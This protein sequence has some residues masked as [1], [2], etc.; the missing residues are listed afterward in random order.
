M[1]F[2]LL[3]EHPDGMAMVRAL[4]ASGRHELAVYSGSAL[5][6]ESLER[7]DLHPARVG[8]LEEVLA[9]PQIEAVVVAGGPAVRSAQ[10]RRALQAERHVLC[11]HP[12]DSSPDTAYEMAMLQNDVGVVLLPLL[13]EALHPGVRRLV[14]CVHGLDRVSGRPDAAPALRE[15]IEPDAAITRRERS[16]PLPAVNVFRLVEVRRSGEEV[17]RDAGLDGQEPG[18]PGWEVLRYLG[19]ELAEVTALSRREDLDRSDVVLLA[20]QFSRGALFQA[21]FLPEHP[22]EEWRLVVLHDLGRVELLFEEGWPGP[23]RLTFVD[24][25]GAS[26]SET[27]PALDLW[28]PL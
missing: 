16:A 8:D 20:G 27:W 4:T 22:V 12:V 24:A 3:G 18:V 21:T 10:V 17:L 25:A 28:Q 26:Q 11:V 15:A 23:A 9:D 6:A 13:P 2:A 14:E 1:R 5:G 19:G 7:W